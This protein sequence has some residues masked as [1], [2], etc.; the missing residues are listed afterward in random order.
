MS[1]SRR[2]SFEEQVVSQIV[3]LAVSLL[4]NAYVT[5]LIV[6]KPVSLAQNLTLTGVFMVASI[7]RGYLLRR[8]YNRRSVLTVQK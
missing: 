3:G 5:P 8:W 2:H 6:G 1:Q 4:L 7:I